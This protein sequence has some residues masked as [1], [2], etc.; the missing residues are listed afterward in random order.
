LLCYDNGNIEKAMNELSDI[1]PQL[2]RGRG[3]GSRPL[4]MKGLPSR[5]GA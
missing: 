4:R 1:G 2:Q 3:A 5:A